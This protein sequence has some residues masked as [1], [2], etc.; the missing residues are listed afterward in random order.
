MRPNYWIKHYFND[1]TNR[2]TTFEFTER[3]TLIWRELPQDNQH[4]IHINQPTRWNIFS[5]LLFDVYVQS[6]C[7]GC[8]HARHQELNNCSS[9]LWFNRWCV[10]I[11]VL[12]VV[13]QPVRSDHDQQH[14]YHHSPT[15]KPEAAPAVVELQTTGVRTPETCWTVHKS[16]I[17]NLRNYCILLTYSM[18]QSPS[19]EANR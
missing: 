6:T 9:S 19:W 7:F 4:F 5:S 10:A 15:V 16:Q 18:E 11:W 17:I 13:V 2:I 14:C 8:P 1:V 3:L 12:L